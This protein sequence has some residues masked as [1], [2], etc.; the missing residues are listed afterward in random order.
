MELK[1]LMDSWKG[2][3]FS[4]PVQVRTFHSDSS[5]TGW[6]GIDLDTNTILQDFWRDKK[7][8]H[9]N[10]KELLA[11]IHTILSFGRKKDHIHLCVDN[12]VTFY[13]LQRGGGR[14]EHLN[15]HMQ[16][17]WRW[18]MENQVTLTTQ[19]VPSAQCRADW[20]SR[21]QDHGDYTLDGQVFT[22]VRQ[23]LAPWVKPNWD[24]FC[25]PS[26]A[27][28]PNF[29]CRFPHHQAKLVNSLHCPLEEVFHCYANPPWTLIG[30]WLHRL[31]KN[32]HIRCLMVCPFWVSAPSWPL[33][34]RMQVPHSLAVK[35]APR[36]GLFINCFHEKMPPTRWPLL[37]V[38]LSGAS[39]RA[40]KK[41]LN[42]LNCI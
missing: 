28:F 2:R 21:G 20:L 10:V 27:K 34:I 16:V 7:F 37:C 17:L 26:N 42:R 3:P 11:A 33:L 35:V 41:H 5:T 13:Y 14:L 9:I 36:E 29:S 15:R 23:L 19:L 30:A 8:L 24:M 6:G 38:T 4:T 32:P 12:T 31:W 40:N 1:S 22:Q 18:L 39:Y 25:S